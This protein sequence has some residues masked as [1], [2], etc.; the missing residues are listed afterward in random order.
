MQCDV[1]GHEN[2]LRYH[3]GRVLC[4]RCF[5]LLPRRR[6]AAARRDGRRCRLLALGDALLCAEHDRRNAEALTWETCDVCGDEH[7]AGDDH[8][9]QPP[10]ARFYEA[11]AAA[12]D[13]R[14]LLRALPDAAR[15][16]V[17]AIIVEEA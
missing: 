1:C 12:L 17:L 7:L 11:R 15:R 8:D 2:D 4:K 16:E 14:A 6:C 13:L 10:T 3:A 5:R 9:C